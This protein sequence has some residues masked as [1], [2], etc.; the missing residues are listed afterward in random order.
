MN[1][2]TRIIPDDG[3]SAMLD[4]F[5][6]AVLTVGADGV[7]VACNPAAARLFGADGAS[8]A[9]M[10]LDDL[11]ADS[12]D[13]A[14]D[15]TPVR[16]DTRGLRINGGGFSTEITA[17]PMNSTGEMLVFARDLTKRHRTEDALKTAEGRVSD[18]T[19]N[20]PVVVFELV[21]DRKGKMRFSY[22]SPSVE[23]LLGVEA[24]E[25]LDQDDALE[26]ITHPGDR[27]RLMKTFLASAKTQAPIDEEYRLMTYGQEPR[28]LRCV[29]RP[30]TLPDGVIAWD[31][32]ALDITSRKRAE[33]HFQYLAFR[34]PL[35]GLLNLTGFQERFRAARARAM[36]NGGSMAVI[37]VGLERFGYVNDILGHAVGDEV[38]KAVGRRLAAETGVGDAI[39]RPGGNVFVILAEGADEEDAARIA[40]DVLDGFE[41]PID[42]REHALEVYA[43]VGVALY[44]RDG[45]DL[46][47][48]MMNSAAALRQA[49]E[50]T[51]GAHRF[52]DKGMNAQVMQAMALE[53]RMRQALR[54]NEFEAY[55]QPQADAKT[56]R[57]VGM[58]AL[59]RWRPDDLGSVPPHEFVAV[60][61][62]TGLVNAIGRKIMADAC[63]AVKGW[64]DA[65]LA[66]PRVAVNVSGRQFGE[67]RKFLAMVQDVL[68]ETGLPPELLE[69]ELTE[70]AVMEHPEDTKKTLERFAAMGISISVDDFGTGYSSMTYLKQ[71]P[72]SK[73][74]IDRAF[75]TDVA[76]DPND[77]AIVDA[78]IA[79]AHAL[80]L[81]TVAEGVEN[82]EQFHYLARRGCDKV[83]GFLFSRALPADGMEA[84]LREGRGLDI[85]PG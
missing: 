23:S 13:F 11:L 41:A 61:E 52:F 19:T 15:P 77:A 57:I 73:L 80:G 20:L 49:R 84:L 35:T 55:F 33:E 34:D 54:D 24:D 21:L 5:P 71:F 70:S 82:W 76:F 44:S 36:R 3:L 38:L 62:A 29:A 53:G 22:L 25:I 83:Q 16:A 42:V 12:I 56:G 50:K 48:L 10:A 74:K 78:T 8:L 65:D 2:P 14:S 6:D 32:V 47:T 27:Q 7:V 39:V 60:A 85:R 45:E 26:D 69:V 67:P 43:S 58:E 9:G 28:W 17:V 4:G 72:I 75:V 30:Q 68:D 46:E 31:G 64:M 79:M 40:R 63:R 37:S 18:I 1:S 81:E 59:A 51:P 66:P